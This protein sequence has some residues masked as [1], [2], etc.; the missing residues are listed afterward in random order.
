MRECPSCSSKVEEEALRC[1]SCG[2]MLPMTIEQEFRDWAGM[3]FGDVE[4]LV[5]GVAEKRDRH[6]RPC[7]GLGRCGG[8]SGRRRLLRTAVIIAGV[9]STGPDD[10]PGQR[11]STNQ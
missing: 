9:L 1:S 6:S 10:H 3:E 2:A 11:K 8:R 4:D 5:H 7:N